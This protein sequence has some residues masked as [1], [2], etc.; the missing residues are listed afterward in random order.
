[1]A[2]LPRRQGRLDVGHKQR[3]V[4]RISRRRVELREVQVEGSRRLGLG[5]DEQGP[6]TKTTT[7]EPQ[8]HAQPCQQNGWN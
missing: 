3:Q 1:M 5:M 7:R 4:E 2:R 6:G 8:V